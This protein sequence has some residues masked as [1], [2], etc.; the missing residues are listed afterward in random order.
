MKGLAM[1][2]AGARTI[3]APAAPG[4]AVPGPLNAD[5]RRNKAQLAGATATD[6]VI[7]PL[8]ADHRV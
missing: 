5:V 1:G 4:R 6:A 2:A 8:L 3:I 7:E